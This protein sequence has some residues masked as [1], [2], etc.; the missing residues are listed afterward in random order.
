MMIM[1]IKESTDRFTYLILHIKISPY[2]LMP[3]QEVLLGHGKL[4]TQWDDLHKRRGRLSN[5]SYKPYKIYKYPA[6]FTI[7]Y[8]QVGERYYRNHESQCILQYLHPRVEH[9]NPSYH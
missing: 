8:K 2:D 4:W 5:G 1:D 3:Q 6:L 9:H 7:L